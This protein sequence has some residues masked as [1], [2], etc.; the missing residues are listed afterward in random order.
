M[1]VFL[2]DSTFGMSNRGRGMQD[3]PLQVREV[4]DIAIDQANG[5]DAGC[6]EIQSGRRAEPTGADKQALSP[7]SASSG[8]CHRR[9]AE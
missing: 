6:S 8:P 7:C 5:A 3:L 4:D 9:P 1:S 2:P